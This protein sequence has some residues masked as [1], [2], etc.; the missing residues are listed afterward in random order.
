MQAHVLGPEDF[1]GLVFVSSPTRV[2]SE[3]GNT[4][5]AGPGSER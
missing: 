1:F 3:E 4:E 2:T 5:G